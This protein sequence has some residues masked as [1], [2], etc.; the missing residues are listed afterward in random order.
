MGVSSGSTIY[1]YRLMNSAFAR[2]FP[3]HRFKSIPMQRDCVIVMIGRVE[4]I[5]FL[6]EIHG[7]FLCANHI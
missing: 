3:N 7:L 6:P 1:I 4:R 2:K 5:L